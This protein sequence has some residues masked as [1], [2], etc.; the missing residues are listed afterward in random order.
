MP[1]IALG[2][3]VIAYEDIGAGPPL[4]MIH[5]GESTRAEYVE[6]FVPYLGD[7]VRALPYDQRDSGDTTNNELPYTM[8]DLATDCAEFIQALGLGSAHILGGSYGGMIALRLAIDY[9]D[10]VRSLILRSTSPGGVV[11]AEDLAQ[12]RAAR[13]T[14]ADFDGDPATRV[15][16]MADAFFSPGHLAGHPEELERFARLLVPRPPERMERRL[17]AAYA[18]DCC[19]DIGRIAA[20]TLILHGSDDPLLR[21][22]QAAWMAERIPD[23]QLVVFE[24]L[25]HGVLLEQPVRA[26]ALIEEFIFAHE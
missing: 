24:G 11:A 3:T 13:L 4:V 19:D 18:H 14:E 22:N 21:V 7:G 8:S 5:G 23:A 9:P 12:V 15:H 25:R 6:N 10:R 2:S 26:A 17:E 1:T 16:R 20:P